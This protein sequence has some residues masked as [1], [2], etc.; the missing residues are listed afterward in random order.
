MVSDEHPSNNDH[1]RVTPLGR[2]RVRL[3]Q[4]RNRFIPPAIFAGALLIAAVS[5]LTA[6]YFWLCGSCF[7]TSGKPLTTVATVAGLKSELGEPSGVA[8]SGDDVFVSDGISGKIWRIAPGADP[9]EF[10]SGL[11]T[12]SAIAFHPSGE[13]IVADTGSH[14]I[15]KIDKTGAVTVLAGTEGRSGDEDGSV[16]NAK[17]NAPIGVAVSG[18]G[19]IVVADTYNDKIKRIREG[20]VTTLAG[21]SR[22]FADGQYINAK[23]DTPC[24]IA[25]LRDGSM[26]VADTMNARIRLISPLG[27]V[28][29]IAG[30]GDADVRDGVLV[31][32]AFYRPYSLG[33]G[34]DGS[35]F[36]GDGNALRVIRNGALPMVQTISKRVRGFA[37]GPLLAS[38]FNRISGIAV[39]DDYKIYLADSDNGAVRR[40]SSD[41]RANG[42]PAIYTP[43][44][45]RTD[46]AEFRGRHPARWPYD[47]P[48]AKR[49]IAGTLGEIRDE[50]VNQNSRPRFHNGLDIAGDF[51]EKARFLRDEKVLNPVSAE[52]FDTLRELI[53]LPAVGYI[54]I[55]LGRDPSNRPLGDPRFQFDTED[56]GGVPRI[57]DVRVR[58]GTEFK[59]GEV[60]G[61]LNAMNHIHMI[62][63]PSGDEMNALDALVLPGIADTIAPTIEEVT[64][65]DQNWLPVETKGPAKRITFT[66]KTRVVVR[67]YDRMDGNPERRRLGVYRLGY[68][69]LNRDLSAVTNVDWNISFDRNPSPDAVKFAYAVGSKSGPTGE[70]IFRYIVTNKVSGEAFSEGFFDPTSLPSGEYV[71]RV[72]AADYFG[73]SSS[74]DIMFAN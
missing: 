53:R 38:R 62:A 2:D 63:G 60:I 30:R 13:L 49:D 35:L 55:R 56:A 26:L 59:A 12:P 10:A 40:I 51:G 57:V 27:K 11:H 34:P 19:E 33:L 47:P 7:E 68:Q 42:E 66:G 5:A 21:S 37:D 16:T 36:I 41:T 39:S 32:S 22:G 61:T 70:T 73:N 15:K 72:F 64:F 48:E 54:H 65:F 69:V 17:F 18:N 67:A 45:R 24:G 4:K 50:Y 1:V 44:T 52:N 8:V 29:T 31:E 43:I 14:T 46:P 9:V 71:L 3:M 25:A 28:S 23:F 6:V 74:K 20:A 58:R